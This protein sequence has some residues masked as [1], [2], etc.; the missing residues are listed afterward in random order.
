[1]KIWINKA[2]GSYV[3]GLVVVAANT[4]YEAHGVLMETD[5]WENQFFI[6]ENWKCVEESIVNCDNPY[7]IGL[8]VHEG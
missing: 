3:G 5:K 1:M 7:I 6:Y 4:Q 2:T 8:D